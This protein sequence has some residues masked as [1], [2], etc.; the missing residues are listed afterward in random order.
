MAKLIVKATSL[1]TAAIPFLDNV[2]RKLAV[3][4][5]SNKTF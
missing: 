3:G 1:A 2:I 4:I 5:A